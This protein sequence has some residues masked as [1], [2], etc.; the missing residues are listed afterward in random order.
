MM[1]FQDNSLDKIEIIK[2]YDSLISQGKY[3]EANRFLNQQDNIYGFFAD[4][5]NAIENRIYNLQKYLLTK[6]K[7]NHFVSSDGPD[8]EPDPITD[9]SIWI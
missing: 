1:F 8:E 6:N 4:Y 7:I 2:E 9:D 3:D 5:F